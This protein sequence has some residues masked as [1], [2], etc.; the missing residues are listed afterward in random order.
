MEGMRIM[1]VFSLFLGENINFIT[2]VSTNNTSKGVINEKRNNID[3]FIGNFI[4]KLK[5]TFINILQGFLIFL[6][7]YNALTRTHSY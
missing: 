4:R 6:K 7:Y 5:R 3:Q 2:G 1:Y